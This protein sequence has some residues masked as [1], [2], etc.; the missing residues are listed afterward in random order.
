[1]LSASRALAPKWLSEQGISIWISLD[2]LVRNQPF[3]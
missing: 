1:M 2:S 3:Q